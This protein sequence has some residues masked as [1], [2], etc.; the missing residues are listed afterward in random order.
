M[1]RLHD[2]VDGLAGRL[3]QLGVLRHA[4][5]LAQ[6]D[7]RDAVAVEP[8]VLRAAGEQVAVGLLVLDQPVDSLADHVR[9]VCRPGAYSRRR[10]TSTAP[11]PWPPYPI[12]FRPAPRRPAS[13][14][15]AIRAS[16]NGRRGTGAGRRNQSALDGDFRAF[17]TAA[18]LQSFLAAADG[19]L[20]VGLG[21][22]AHR[23][24][25]G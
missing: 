24:V 23:A 19:A 14:P 17:V 21:R 12:A 25:D 7:G 10:D 4:V 9:G 13:R 16:S 11:G 15:A 5:G 3:A 6:G 2:E 18:G 20:L 22:L 1:L 8:R